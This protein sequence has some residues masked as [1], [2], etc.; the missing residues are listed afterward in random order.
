MD[1]WI[2]NACHAEISE[3]HKPHFCPLCNQ[4]KKGFDKSE[5]PEPTPEDEEYTKRYKKVIKE[6]E[7]YDDGCDPQHNPV[8]CYEE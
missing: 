4:N 1:V 2:C 5:K 6:L 8:A 7:S 3:E